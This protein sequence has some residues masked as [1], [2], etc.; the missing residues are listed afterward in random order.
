MAS[1]DLEKEYDPTQ[2]SSRITN[3]KELRESHVEFGNRVSDGN[4]YA[5][6]CLLNFSYGETFRQQL[7]IYGV[8]LA[9]DAPIIVYVHGGYWQGMNKYTSSYAVKPF[10]DSGAKVFVIDHDLCPD[11]PLTEVINQFQTAAERIFSYAAEHNSKSVS[12]I[13]HQSGAHLI[14][15]LFTPDMI[16]RLGDGFNLVKNIYLISGV[17]DVSELRNTKTVNLDNLLSIDD[18]NVE[19]LSPVKQ[20][21]DHLKTYNVVFDAFVGGDESPTLQR[22]SR[23]FIAHLKFAKLHANFTLMEGLDHFN[24]VEKLSEIN[25]DITQKVINNLS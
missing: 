7:D 23:E 5:I 10:V 17:Y 21:F 20:S 14:T 19:A 15:Y 2:W 12:F 22:H 3:P 13:G 6:N 24:I 18:G 8:S 25:Y 9:T 4:R 16:K 1:R 11:V